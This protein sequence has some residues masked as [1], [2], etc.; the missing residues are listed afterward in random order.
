MQPLNVPSRLVWTEDQLQR[1]EEVLAELENAT[2]NGEGVLP[3][4]R[5]KAP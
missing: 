1:V 3:A 4:P 2:P 5:E